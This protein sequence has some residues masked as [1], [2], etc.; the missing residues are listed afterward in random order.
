MRDIPRALAVALDRE[1][2][3]RG[4]SLNQ[5]IK[6]L[7][8]RALG[9]EPEPF[10]NGLGDLAGSWSEDELRRFERDTAFLGEIDDELW[11]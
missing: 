3:R 10:D 5:T 9:L 1:R 6:D 4:V 11:R 8:G 2:K 7:L